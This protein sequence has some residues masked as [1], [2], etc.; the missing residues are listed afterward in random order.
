MIINIV[1]VRVVELSDGLV[2]ALID[3]LIL[4]WLSGLTVFLC[5]MNR[6]LGKP[7]WRRLPNG[8]I[9]FQ[10][11]IPQRFQSARP[12]DATAP[13]MRDLEQPDSGATIAAHDT[14]G[15]NKCGRGC[16][17]VILD[18]TDHAANQVAY[19]DTDQRSE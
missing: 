8:R 9:R 1:A 12:P 15:R 4:V 5:R 2:V 18:I 16:S 10:W 7:V 17:W 6:R 19:Q 11:G 3:G 14:H 13:T